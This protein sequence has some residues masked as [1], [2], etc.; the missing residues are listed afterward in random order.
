MAKTLKDNFDSSTNSGDAARVI[1]FTDR[2]SY[3]NLGSGLALTRFLKT[4]ENPGQLS[5]ILQDDP[6]M[7]FSIFSHKSD[8]KA[9]TGPAVIYPSSF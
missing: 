6:I 5:N 8:S 7:N 3:S 9:H 1:S 4:E 2:Y